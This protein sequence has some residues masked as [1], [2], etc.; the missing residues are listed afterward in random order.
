MN[1]NFP[2]LTKSEDWIVLP[3]DFT[4]NMNELNFIID[5]QNEFTN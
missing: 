1:H 2:S 3:F 4:D 5:E